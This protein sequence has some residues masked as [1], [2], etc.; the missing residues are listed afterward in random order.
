MLIVQYMLSFGNGILLVYKLPWGVLGPY[1][2]HTSF[3]CHSAGE[4]LAVRPYP[5]QREA[6]K[7]RV[8]GLT[9]PTQSQDCRGVWRVESGGKLISATIYFASFSVG[10]FIFC[11]SVCVRRL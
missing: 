9:N 10:L 6:K 3:S 2:W 7:C 8:A 11:F 4:N 1:S 5:F